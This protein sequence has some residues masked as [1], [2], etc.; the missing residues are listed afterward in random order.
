MSSTPETRSTA[1]AEQLDILCDQIVARLK[2]VGEA[3]TITDLADA[4]NASAVE[5]H[6]ATD[7]LVQAKHICCGNIAVKQGDAP[8]YSA[9]GFWHPQWPAVSVLGKV[10]APTQSRT[11]PKYSGLRDDISECAAMA[12]CLRR[13]LELAGVADEVLDT[14]QRAA[15]GLSRLLLADIR[16]RGVLA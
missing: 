16:R 14:L 10:E 11:T 8:T 15:T 5:V 4:L 2:F 12:L 7:R 1:Q 13:D 3:Q 6:A 9:K